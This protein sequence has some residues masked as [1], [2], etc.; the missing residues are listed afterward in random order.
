MQSIYK[1]SSIFIILGIIIHSEKGNVSY[2]FSEFGSTY[3]VD[4]DQI[5]KLVCTLR[6]NS[7]D[8]VDRKFFK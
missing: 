2:I 1:V 7:G 3:W 8:F 4:F 5:Q 6:K